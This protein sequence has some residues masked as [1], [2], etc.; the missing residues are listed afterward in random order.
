LIIADSGFNY[1]AIDDCENEFNY[2]YLCNRLIMNESEAI[3]IVKRF[4]SEQFPKQCTCCGKRYSSLSE[5][6]KGT[7]TVGKPISYDAE[8]NN[9]NPVKPAGTVSISNCSCGSSLSLSSNGMEVKTL[10]QLMRWARKEAKIQGID[11][12]DFLDIL[13]T[14]FNTSVLNDTLKKTKT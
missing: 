9:W 10:L 13:R 7:K 14:K 5:Y 8:N 6:I 12:S 3:K 4:L 11:F 2:Q 1:H